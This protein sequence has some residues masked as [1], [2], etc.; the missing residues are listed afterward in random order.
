[1]HFEVSPPELQNRRSI[2]VHIKRSLILPFFLAF[3]GPDV[4]A[5]CP[6]RFVT[7]QPTQSLSMLNGD[8]LNQQA[9]A[10]ADYLHQNAGNSPRE[11]VTAA[12]WR[13]LQRSP[14]KDE[15]DRGVGLLDSLQQDHQVDA[16][17]ALDYYCL[18]VLNLNE[19][20]SLD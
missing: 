6:V 15:V 8:F 12:L 16:D 10:L 4:D 3:D 5:T 1:M 20:V 2:Y 18:I 17:R 19:F 7:T 14:G 13:V 9:A 11:F